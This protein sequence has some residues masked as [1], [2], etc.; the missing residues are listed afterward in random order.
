MVVSRVRNANLPH[1]SVLDI[2]FIQK[3]SP[4]I[5]REGE[6]EWEGKGGRETE[7]G[8]R[9]SREQAERCLIIISAN[10]LKLNVRRK[11]C[12]QEIGAGSPLA[13]KSAASSNVELRYC[14]GWQFAPEWQNLSTAW[15][16]RYWRQQCFSLSKSVM[17]P[18]PEVR[19]ES[20]EK[21]SALW[22]V[23]R[24]WEIGQA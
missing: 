21:L 15:Q 7:G 19:S 13:R 6:R 11:S 18:S 2:P 24:W 17:Q 8:E 16:G 14:S 1:F 22:S 3:L 20:L 23:S 4:L 10:V 9:E 12:F 5:E